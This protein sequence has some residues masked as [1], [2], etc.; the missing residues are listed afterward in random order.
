[1]KEIKPFQLKYHSLEGIGKEFEK[2]LGNSRY[3][4]NLH[5]ISN[6]LVSYVAGA[7]VDLAN[8]YY[9]SVLAATNTS[10]KE[11]AAEIF[12]EVQNAVS[13]IGGE[14]GIRDSEDQGR[15]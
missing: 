1:M 14:Y 6:P 9:A 15:S 7:V 3:G 4:V 10:R 2:R 5:D 12:K 13:S 8:E 11:V